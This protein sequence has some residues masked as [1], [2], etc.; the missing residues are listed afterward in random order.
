MNRWRVRSLLLCA[1]SATGFAH[2]GAEG[3]IL[4][5]PYR[6][7]EV[8]AVRGHV[9]YALELELQPGERVMNVAAGNLS[10][11]EVGVEANHV[12]LKPRQAPQRTNVTVVTD[13]RT[14]RLDYAVDPERNAATS[15]YIYALVFDYPPAPAPVAPPRADPAPSPSWN[16]DYWYCGPAELRPTEAFDD[17]ARTYIRF[18]P[19][20]EFP[21]TYV[22][23]ATGGERLV[24]SHVAGDW[25]IVHQT[26]RRLVLRRGVL[27]GCLDNRGTSQRAVVERPVETP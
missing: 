25:I 10:A 15:P 24:N 13:R 16:G 8:V 22:A 18:A 21:V 27:A 11:I 5:L 23:D 19:A 20:T 14:Y 12:F 7:D 2:A 6:D 17:G 3:R 4:Q 26:A 1:I 9:G